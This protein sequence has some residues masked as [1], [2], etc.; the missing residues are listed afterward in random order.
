MLDDVRKEDRTLLDSK[1]NAITAADTRFEIVLVWMD[2]L[3][4]EARGISP[5]YEGHHCPIAGSLPVRRKPCVALP[6]LIRPGGGADAW[7]GSQAD[8]PTPAPA[9]ALKTVEQCLSLIGRMR[10]RDSTFGKI[11]LR[12]ANSLLHLRMVKPELVTR[13]ERRR[14][15]FVGPTLRQ[16]EKDEVPGLEAQ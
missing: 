10:D 8:L 5:L 1:H 14:H 15:E 12:P 11:C 13:H 2:G 3:H 16:L 6:P 9:L 4:V 7:T